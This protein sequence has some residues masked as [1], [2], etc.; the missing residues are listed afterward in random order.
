MMYRQSTYQRG[1]ATLCLP[2]AV[3]I[4][5]I[6]ATRLLAADILEKL[7]ADIPGYIILPH[8]SESND[9]LTH[10]A[11]QIAKNYRPLELDEIEDDLGIP[12]GAWNRDKPV[13]LIYTKPTFEWTSA[14][15]AFYP[16]D[17][18][19]FA[20]KNGLISGR[21]GH[22]KIGNMNLRIIMLDDIA[23]ISK[24]LLPLR[25]LRRV[26]PKAT[27]KT[28]TDD[29][30]RAYLQESEAVIH[31]NLQRWRETVCPMV[32]LATN[33]MQLGVAA[34]ANAE[35]A[36]AAR[37]ILA[38][39]GSGVADAVQQMTSVTVSL[40]LTNESIVLEHRHRFD[41]Q[42]YFSRYFGSVTRE[43][44]DLFKTL[45]N[46][47]FWLM[48]ASNWR[49][50]PGE[51]MTTK[52]TEFVM[53][54]KLMGKK[55]SDERVKKVISVVRDCYGQMKGSAFMLSSQ[56]G[57]IL[58]MEMIG[59]YVL[60]NAKE[61]AK[62]ICFIQ[63][64]ANEAMSILVPCGDLKSRFESKEKDGIRYDEM[65]LEPELMGPLVRKQMEQTYGLSARFQNAVVSP[66][67]VAFCMAEPPMSVVS[68]AK[69]RK[70]GV[71]SL[72]DNDEVQRIAR[73][74]QNKPNVIVLVDLD[75]LL[76]AIPDLAAQSGI[77]ITVKAT[78]DPKGKRR[79]FPTHIPNHSKTLLGWSC[80]V[81]RGELTGRLAIDVDDAVSAAEG[82]R[83]VAAQISPGARSAE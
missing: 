44:D 30:D 67:E 79:G 21:S 28:Q 81:Q 23:F 13:A 49:S 4:V 57:S 27:A 59:S 42:G 36:A 51:A 15:V 65:R 25:T 24:R 80:V 82:I 40:R 55:M 22:I 56:K 18:K 70:S 39:F 33:M 71:A 9:K 8:L 74:L 34:E 3:A 43:A 83:R 48:A 73:R 46:R 76:A 17:P 29:V 14:I 26:D 63:E 5:A 38:W 78:D 35:K 64:N 68:L 1:R 16:N 11:S 61:G 50:P 7:P 6:A 58:P 72:A 20:E 66:T 62:Q 69:S 60:E 31:L 54:K 37:E 52:L 47:P 75:R 12:S 19:A 41:P 10:I 45:P 77:S 2:V 32:T 53:S